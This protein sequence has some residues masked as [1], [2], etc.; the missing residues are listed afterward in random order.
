LELSG[1]GI[2]IFLLLFEP[3]QPFIMLARS[4]CWTKVA[5]WLWFKNIVHDYEFCKILLSINKFTFC[6]PIPALW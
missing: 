6:T 2:G 3:N 4:P 5:I 1:F